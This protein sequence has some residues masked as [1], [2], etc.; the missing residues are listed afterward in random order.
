MYFT[1]LTKYNNNFTKVKFQNAYRCKL[2][3][4]F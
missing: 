4:Y 2:N 3:T 1:D